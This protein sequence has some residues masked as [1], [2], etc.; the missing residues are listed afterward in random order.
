[1][2]T[3]MTLP[4][5]PTAAVKAMIKLAEQLIDVMERESM[6]LAKR[7][8]VTF[9]GLQDEKSRLSGQY[10]A[11]SAAFGAR[12]QEFRKVDSALIDKLGALQQSLKDKTLENSSVMERMQG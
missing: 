10:E 12:L 1:M 4:Q 6:A 8:G 9:T 11:G 7:D 5:D 2:S 3:E